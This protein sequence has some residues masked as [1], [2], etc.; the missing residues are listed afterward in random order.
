MPSTYSPILGIE[1]ISPGEQNNTWGYTTN[2]NLGTLIE[3]AIAG[4]AS[5]T[6]TSSVHVLTDTDGTSDEARCM[7]LNVGGVLAAT[8]TVKCP[9]ATKVYV[10]A[11]NTTGDQDI[12]IVS[13]AAGSI[14]VL[15]PAGCSK[16][17]FC[18]GTNVY[19]SVN[20]VDTLLIGSSPTPGSNEAATAAYVDL[21]VAT[22][23]V[24][25]ASRALVSNSLGAITASTTTS[26]EVG[27]LSGVTSAVQTQLNAKAPSTTGTSILKGNG[28]GGFSSA[29]ASTDYAPA[30]SGTAAQ[31]LGSNGTGG[32]SN[33]TVGSTLN[34]AAGT[35]NLGATSVVAGSYS[36]ANITVDSYGRV[37]S[38]TNGGGAGVAAIKST[39][40]IL[41]DGGAGPVTGSPTISIPQASGTVAGYLA[42]ADWT[43]FNNKAAANA[44]FTLGSTSIAL[45]STALTVAGL[46]LTGAALNGT[47]GAT[48]P[49]SIVGTT[50]TANVSFT[51]PH[52]GTVGATTPSTGSFTS[53]NASGTTTLSS[54]LNGMLKAVSGVITNATAGT[55]FVAP[56][57]ALGT[58]LSGNLQYCSGLPGSALTG[59]VTAN[60]IAAGT[61]TININGSSTSCSGNA[62]T[63]SSV[64]WTGVSGRPTVVSAFTNDAGYITSSALSGYATQSYVTSQGYITSGGSCAYATNSGNANYANSS[65]SSSYAFNLSS[66][67][68]SHKL[69]CQGDGNTVMYYGGG[70]VWNV[71]VN[72]Y[73]TFVILYAYSFSNRST[74][75]SKDEVATY[76]KGLGDLLKL[77]PVTFKYKQ[78]EGRPSAPTA[79]QA[80]FIAEE[81]HEA[82]L[83]EYVDYDAD[84]E[85]ESL[86]YAN[87]VALMTKAIQDLNS[88][89]ES[90]QAEVTALKA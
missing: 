19:E 33:V 10:V 78:E 17:V 26:T 89:V 29:V 24:K 85:P 7:I 2:N 60:A 86:K 53:L 66:D 81:V 49:A 70:A 32:F 21:S 82:G 74:I 5:I 58:P 56:G 39:S 43:T 45:G 90:L 18:D 40:P 62:A 69:V 87:M 16:V 34:Y 11:N 23:T 9:T 57:G 73:G 75:K 27:Y 76:E 54:A 44:T 50:I 80:G 37:T 8:G 31:L 12:E 42:A 79:T 52:N 68:G 51:G 72:G 4:Q 41:V 25:T 88:K 15:V 36:S 47:L 1:L 13:T 55:D 61:Y 6:M 38:A 67:G 71:D 83:T 63:A 65:G 46:T 28:T 48:T 22:A 3:Q 14:G 84:G 20:A 30:T 64:N 59:T 35:L 77:R